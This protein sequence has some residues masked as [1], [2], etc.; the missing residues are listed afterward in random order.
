MR[1]TT[2]KTAKAFIGLSAGGI[3]VAIYHAYDEITHYSTSVGNACH[4]NST[5]NCQAT[6]PYGHLFGIPLYIFGLVWFPLLL[7][8]SLVMRSNFRKNVLV[9]LVMVGNIFTLY[10]WYLDLAIVL[11]KTGAICPVCVSMYIIN[12]VLTALVLLSS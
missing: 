4:L 1:T 6:F 2:T 3:G 10:L 8:A 7:G 12:Y 11:P 5:L 9:P